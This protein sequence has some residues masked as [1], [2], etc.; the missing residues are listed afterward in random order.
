MANTIKSH[1]IAPTLP[2]DDYFTPEARALSQPVKH[3]SELTDD[4]TLMLALAAA[5]AALAWYFH[6]GARSAEDAL[7]AIGA[8][9]DHEDVVAALQ[10]KLRI[11]GEKEKVFR[12]RLDRPEPES[13]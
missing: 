13:G 1:S 3:K 9:L 11:D 10:R 5:Q 8:L 2:D 6:P 12:T 7:N 4:E